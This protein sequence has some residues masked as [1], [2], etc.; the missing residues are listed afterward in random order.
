MA[1]KPFHWNRDVSGIS[2]QEFCLVNG[3]RPCTS[4]RKGCLQRERPEDPNKVRE[5]FQRETGVV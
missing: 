1:G 5:G 3:K 4:L 2:N